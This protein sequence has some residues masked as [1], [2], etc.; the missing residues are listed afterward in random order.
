MGFVADDY[1]RIAP[2]TF[3]ERKVPLNKH[4]DI[5]LQPAAAEMTAVT[6]HL[7]PLLR[8]AYVLYPSQGDINLRGTEK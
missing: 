8:I 6:G 5:W 1:F 2:G 7:T 3:K 4:F